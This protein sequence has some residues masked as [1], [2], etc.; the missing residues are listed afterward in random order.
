[1]RLKHISLTASDITVNAAMA[2]GR[3][4]SSGHCHN[5]QSLDCARAFPDKQSLLAFLEPIKNLSFPAMRHLDIG[6]ASMD[7][8]CSIVFGEMI[9]AGAFPKLEKLWMKGQ[10][11][12]RNVWE[13]LEVWSC[14]KLREL[15]LRFAKLTSDSAIALV[16]A[17]TSGALSKLQRISM[18]LGRLGD[19]GDGDSSVV[20]VLNAVAASC[21]D[22]RHLNASCISNMREQ[23]ATGIFDALRERRWP[24]LEKP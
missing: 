12:H 10:P 5:L 19:G 3:V 7:E 15:E 2:F 23:A 6:N 8:E 22:M 11:V 18:P 17:L 14:P 16:S 1:M 9:G 13:A 4:L 24:K 21:P 20:N